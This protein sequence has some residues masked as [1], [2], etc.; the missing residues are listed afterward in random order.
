MEIIT[1]YLS[2]GSEGL[3]ETSAAYN[4][5]NLLA[6]FDISHCS[7]TEKILTTTATA[8]TSTI[9]TGCATTTTE[10]HFVVFWVFVD[11]NG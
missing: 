5:K 11:L 8:E 10:R 4:R 6:P 7:H 3:L 9:G 1:Q 2:W